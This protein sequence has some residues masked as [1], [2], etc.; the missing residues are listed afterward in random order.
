MRRTEYFSELIQDVTFACRQLLKAPGFATV[1]ILT[2]ALGIGAT[3]AIFSAVHAVVLRPLPVPNP[4]RIVSVYEVYQGNQRKRFRRQLRRRHRAG[5]RASA[6]RRP[7][8]TRAS[9]SPIEGNSERV[10]GGR[11]T[12]GFFRVFATAPELGRVYTDDE[13]QPGREQVV[14]L[15]NRLWTRWFGRDRSV[16]RP[17]DPSQRAALRGHRRDAGAFRLHRR[18]RGAVGAG[19][20]HGRAQGAARRALPADLRTP[21]AW[22]DDGARRSRS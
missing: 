7:F 20:V 15:S 2:L 14:V 19:R 6:T 1:A 16:D 17:S 12:A 22:C 21:E 11:T 5:R 9:T 10:I 13:D 18:E 3:T 4:D 8:S